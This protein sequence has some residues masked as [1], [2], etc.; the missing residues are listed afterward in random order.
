MLVA[1]LTSAPVLCTLA[2]EP[3]AG[4]GMRFRHHFVHKG[5][6]T[7]RNERGFEVG[8]YGVTALADLDR[9]GD[10]DFVTGRK[11]DP[12][13]RVY[14][15]EYRGPDDWA[16]H[17]LGERTNSDVGGDGLDVNGDGWVDL[18]CSGVWF[19]NP[20]GTPGGDPRRQ[21]FERRVFDAAG[22]GAH[23]VLATADVDG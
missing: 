13:W 17:E 2:R 7:Y 5:L 3:D 22:G 9:N 18:V 21:P 16:Q 20:G 10:L 19:R 12:D 23:D 15:F 11:G 1:C 8:D 6:P 14:W 4:G